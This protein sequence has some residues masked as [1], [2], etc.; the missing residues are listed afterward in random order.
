MLYASLSKGLI[1]L[2]VALSCWL[3]LASA[4][5]ASTYPSPIPLVQRSPYFGLWLPANAT[6]NFPGDVWANA[7]NGRK[8]MWPG[9]VRV[10]GRSW[11][12]QGTSAAPPTT[13]LAVY[14][15]PTRT[16]FTVDAGPVRLN[17]TFL[18]PIEPSDWVLQSLPFSYLSID[19]WSTDGNPHSVQLYTGITGEFVSSSDNSPVQWGTTQTTSSVFHQIKRTAALSM[20]ENND[21]A[22]DGIAYLATSA[23]T[24][25]L[26]WQ[27]AASETTKHE[28]S[29]NGSMPNTQDTNFR[30]INDGWP[31]VVLVSDL[32]TISRTASPVVFALGL[33]RDPVIRYVRDGGIETRRSYFWTKYPLI[34]QAIDAFLADFPGAMSRA[35]ALDNKIMTEA[36]SISP[37]YAD[38]AAVS[39]RQTM[40]SIEITASRTMA[41]DTEWN[42]TDI[43]VFM[44]DVGNSRRVNPVEIMYAAFPAF[45][46]LNASLAGLMLDPLLEFQSSRQYGNAYAA[47]DLGNAFPDAMGNNTNTVSL[48]VDSSA[49]MLIMA[50]AHAQKSGE[51]AMMLRSYP[52]L[53]KWADYLVLNALQPNGYTTS[54]GLSNSM[55]NL[56]FKG[57]MGIYAM[58]KINQA[59]EP[60]G[61]LANDTEHYMTVARNYMSDWED[62]AFSVDHITSSYGNP[63]SWGLVYNLYASRLLNSGLIGE[64]YLVAQS[65]WY[66]SKAQTAPAFGLPYDTNDPNTVKAHWTMFAAASLY[67][68]STR[69]TLISMVH[70]RAFMN[71]SG[72]A[73]PT[74]YDPATGATL[75]TRGGRAS[76]AY[77]AVFAPL[78]LTY[79]AWF[80]L[81]LIF[82]S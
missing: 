28:F 64:G 71:G 9:Y 47:P 69:D 25:G 53:R 26:T 82:P 10:D 4:Q 23:S 59:L 17:L 80:I 34:D 62:L 73:M 54:D 22:E 40:G 68:A 12:W 15:T 81:S 58:S 3:G 49:T 44:K 11:Q 20:V 5:Y 30:A 66:A 48:G 65:A 27:T 77:G 29:V 1:Q 72:Y 41:G 79:V 7:W 61:M 55:S 33:V 75:G 39:L 38:L 67:N 36:A 56:A 16:I 51:G 52:L 46:Y 70:S 78:A 13:T 19:A 18:S 2:L 14:V 24:P 63:N 50:L 42:M 21:S 32:G 35:I 37:Q 57:I 31:V 43:M 76:P 6:M 8:Q 60:Q 45:L 74:S